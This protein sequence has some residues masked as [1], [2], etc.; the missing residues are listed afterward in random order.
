MGEQRLDLLF[1]DDNFSFLHVMLTLS[2]MK[3]GT[4]EPD[5]INFKKKTSALRKAQ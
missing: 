5:F 2:S 4:D 3:E 1:P